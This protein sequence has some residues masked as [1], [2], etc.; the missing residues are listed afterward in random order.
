ME[1]SGQCFIQAV[2][3][4][5]TLHSS[6]IPKAPLS[7]SYNSTGSAHLP[8]WT[9]EENK[10]VVYLSLLAG[11]TPKLPVGGST[12]GTWYYNQTALVFSGN[13]CTNFTYTKGGNT[14]PLF[15]RTTEDIGTSGNP[16]LAPALKINGNLATG[17]NIDI[18]Q[19]RWEGK[20]ELDGAEHDIKLAL[21]IRLS[22]W[23]GSGFLGQILFANGVNVIKTA[24]GSVTATPR[25]FGDT[26]ML[27]SEYRCRW[28]LNGSYIPN[29]DGLYSV[30]IT[31]A[32]VVDYA[33]LECEFYKYAD[34]TYQNCLTV[35]VEGIDDQQ[36]PEYM[37]INHEMY[38]SGAWVNQEIRGGKADVH[39]DEKVRF[40]AWM[41]TET[42]EAVDDT[43]TLIARYTGI[44]GTT[45][46]AP[47]NGTAGIASLAG[48][49][50]SSGYYQMTKDN[51]SKKWRTPEVT[52]AE[53]VDQGMNVS[54]FIKATK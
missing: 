21:P 23:S 45:L 48:K 46:A 37:Y 15:V 33:T 30:T 36:D 47:S 42:N 44:N 8:D 22:E 11:A 17:G 40:V 2:G 4:G 18:D 3:S 52:F 28:K 41:G 43:W 35:A 50:A 34:S 32:Q 24:N 38:K 1:V 29:T 49:T 39:K 20:G 25:L 54:V 7:Q 9:V 31:Q 19:I 5:E 10:P 12:G 6:L 27:T 13:N 53:A 16:V 26:E 51:T 14:Y